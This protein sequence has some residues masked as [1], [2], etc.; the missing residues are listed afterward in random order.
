MNLMKRH[1]ILFLLLATLMPGFAQQPDS[2]HLVYPIPNGQGDPTQQLYNQSPLYL[3]DPRNF[4]REVIYDPVT[5]QYTFK[6]KVGDFE[7]TTPTTMSQQEYL[8]YKNRQGVMEYWKERRKQNGRSATDGNSIIP[9]IYVGGEAFDMIFG[10]NTIDIRPQGSV[11]LSFGIK[12]N[13]RGDPSMSERQKHNTN[14]DFDQDIQLNVIAKIGDKINFNLNK[15]TKAT[16]NYEDLMKLKYEGKEDEI[17]Q[18][19]EA[20]DVSVPLNSTLITG[21]QRLFG[22]KSKLKFGK[23]TVT[24]VVSYQES[25]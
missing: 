3:S 22:L 10:S 8:N 13:Y 12:H 25:E 18:L 9:P 19:L 2:T 23:T 1:I 5:N 14:F 24:G 7:Y 6:H 11:D 4:T 16:F 17:I 20:G 21:T 15:N